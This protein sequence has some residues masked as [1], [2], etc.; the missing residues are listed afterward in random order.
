MSDQL[1]RTDSWKPRAQRSYTIEE[2]TR[3][4]KVSRT[5]TYSEIKAGRLKA[6]KIGR[7]TVLLDGDIADWQDSLEA[8]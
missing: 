2:F 4:Y 1:N 7:R 8:A 5:L 3:E 6:R